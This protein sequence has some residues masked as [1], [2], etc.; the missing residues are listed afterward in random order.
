MP[1]DIDLPDDVAD[2][3]EYSIIDQ[4]DSQ[5]T[6]PDRQGRGHGDDC[7]CGGHDD[8]RHSP[9]GGDEAMQETLEEAVGIS[10]PAEHVGAFV[11]EAFED[12]ERDTTWPDVVAAFVDPSARG[13]WDDLDA[14]E[15]VVEI[16]DAA[17]RYDDRAI[18]HFESIPLDTG[19]RSDPDGLEEALRCRRNADMFRDGIAAAYGDGVLD[20]A[21]LVTAV[22]TSAFDTDRI[23]DRENALEN[24][25]A[26]HDVD[27]RP[28]GGQFFDAEHGPDSDVDHDASETW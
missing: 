8:A 19:E 4:D 20:D 12:A 7:E 13:A 24:V 22:E 26:V 14:S 27:F 2:T 18:E 23:A 25:D 1:Y 6:Q 15:Q 28:Y 10:I 21:D 3:D 9:A 5:G 17:S 11:A 16:L